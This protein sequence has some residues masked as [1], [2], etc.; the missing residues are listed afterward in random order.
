MRTARIVLFG[1]LALLGLGIAGLASFVWFGGADAHRWVAH[2]VLEAAL[3]HDVQ[4]D[5]DLTVVL[6]AEPLLQLTDLRIDSPPWAE[7]PTLLEVDRAEIRIALRP[8]L[9]RVVVFPHFALDG[10][11]ASFETAADGRGSWETDGRPGATQDR[12]EGV[13]LPIFEDVSVS[14]ATV[15]LHDLQD[16][17]RNEVHIASLTNRIDADTGGT[18][19]DVARRD[20]RPGLRDRR[21]GRKSSTWRWPRSNPIP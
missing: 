2:K 7:S 9:Q 17:R 16:G 5:G 11:R 1:T 19:L 10:V 20:Q 12:G 3:D 14:D 21:D 8:L 13:R 6:G 18:R 4:I 15:L